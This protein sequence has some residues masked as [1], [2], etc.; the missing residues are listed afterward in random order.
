VELG[1]DRGDNHVG[2]LVDR[3]GGNPF[4]LEELA[5]LVIDR[6][7]GVGRGSGRRDE[8]FEI[9]LSELPATLRG[10][11]SARLDA[12]D[13]GERA[14]LENAAVLG[15]TGSVQALRIVA[16][17][18]RGVGTD[19]FEAQLL[20]LVD[21][22]LLDV[23]GP[24]FRFH[25]DLVRDV[26]YGRLT[27]AVRARQHRGIA[28]YLERAQGETIRNSVVVAIA[29]HYRAAAQL[30]LELPT[31]PD[32]DHPAL[33]ERALY[34]LE[35]AGDRA[36]DVG[37]PRQAARWYDYGV[38]LADDGT[39]ARF[40]FG[41]ARART[42]I[43]DLPGARADLERLAT[44]P[45]VSPELAARVLLVL[46]DVN[47]KAGDHTQAVVDLAGAADR[48]AQLGV[49][50]QQALALRLLGMTEMARSDEIAARRALE[51]SRRVAMAAGDRRSEGWALQSM[52][53]HAFR[54]GRV[55]EARNLVAD[56]MGIFTEVGDN[57]A[58]MWAQGVLAWVAFH[59][60]DWAEARSLIDTILP[61]IRRRGDPW[62]EA[63]TLNLDASLR[64]WSGQAEEAIQL[65]LEARAVAESI[66]QV[67]LTVTAR[68]VEGR[69][70]VS[71]GRIDEGTQVLDE[72]FSVADMAGDDNGRRMAVV[73]NTASAARLGEPERAIRWAARYH[74]IAEDPTVVGETD[75][76]VSLAL[77]LL[78]RG[79]VAEATLQLDWGSEGEGVAHFA[80]AVGALVA[81]AAGD[82]E[83][84]EE[85]TGRAVTGQS[86]YLDRVVALLARATVRARVGD[87]E[88]CD[89]ALDGARTEVAMTD[90]QLTRHLIGLA[91][92]VCGRADLVEAEARMRN[93]GLD[94]AGW[95]NAF[96][97]AAQ[98]SAPVSRGETKPGR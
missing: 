35:Q 48:L 18:V 14:L 79:A 68:A 3:S 4:F 22:D 96:S 40:V 32:L 7:H 65:A 51:A 47:R 34:W 80:N 1:L 50:S 44:L 69:A 10:T 77:A 39:L 60:G 27:K 87:P 8:E 2:D 70:L 29:D 85:L 31:V 5:G 74:G 88:G 16:A 91:A 26:A 61:E 56:A 63:I 43:H 81:A 15:R 28:E 90:D 67:T 97:L 30:S 66:D 13:P 41:R 45:D 72:A 95:V 11:I 52:A 98:P 42:E 33:V 55:N 24:R 57:G 49:P 71:L 64:L 17:E 78:Q 23:S 9:E 86:T 54:L 36:L 94:P 75:L 37:E 6:G 82:L 38:E 53:W 89:A 92:A 58:L 84:S 20:G 62:A 76:V 21:Q 12:L 19:E 59:T 46:G 93:R 73:T 25:S 83:L